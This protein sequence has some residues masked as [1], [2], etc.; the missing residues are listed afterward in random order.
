MV[1]TFRLSDL[2]RSKIPPQSREQQLARL[3]QW[4]D[5]QDNLERVCKEQGIPVP[6]MVC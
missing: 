5:A 6:V 2:D 1:R 3:K 4:Q